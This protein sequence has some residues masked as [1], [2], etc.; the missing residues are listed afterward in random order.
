MLVKQVKFDKNINLKKKIFDYYE[1]LFL[2]N[3]DLKTYIE[4][5]ERSFAEI[6]ILNG[7][8]TE[9]INEEVKNYTHFNFNFILGNNMNVLKRSKFADEFFKSY[10]KDEKKFLNFGYMNTEYYID[11]KEKLFFKEKNIFKKFFIKKRLKKRVIDYLEIYKSM[12]L[13][14]GLVH[15]SKKSNQNLMNLSAYDLP[16]SIDYNGYI[17]YRDGAHRR[18]IAYYL[19]WQHLSCLHFQFNKIDKTYLKEFNKNLYDYFDQF[20]DIINR[21]NE[22]QSTK[23]NIKKTKTY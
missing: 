22:G 13:N 21:L 12:K 18:S 14:K 7:I 2:I 19:K 4:F 16:L 8:F 9:I 6:C 1:H 20:S 11:M 10:E 17:K 23:E 15:N 5:F 3:K